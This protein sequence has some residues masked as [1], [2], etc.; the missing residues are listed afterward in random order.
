MPRTKVQTTGIFLK[1]SQILLEKMDV[2]AKSKGL[3]R[4][5]FTRLLIQNA[6][7][8]EEDKQKK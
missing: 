8:K 4:S 6:V 5:E 7:E 3:S 2:V 1:I